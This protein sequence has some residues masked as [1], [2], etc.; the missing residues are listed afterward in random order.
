M[1]NSFLG[2]DTKNKEPKLV[3]VDVKAGDCY[4]C[5]FSMVVFSLILLCPGLNELLKDLRME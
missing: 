3:V 1:E 4:I 2:D 5:E